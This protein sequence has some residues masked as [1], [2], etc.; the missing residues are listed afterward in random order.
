M[1]FIEGYREANIPNRASTSTL[2][3]NNITTQRT[4]PVKEDERCTEN[5]DNNS[6]TARRNSTTTSYVGITPKMNTGEAK[7]E[8]TVIT[9]RQTTTQATEDGVQIEETTMQSSLSQATAKLQGDAPACPVCGEITI[10]NGTCYKCMN[11]G[12]SLGCS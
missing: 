2:P 8:Q 9:Q 1:Q 10:R 11:C 3:M 4:T 7:I 5:A 6:I 12:N